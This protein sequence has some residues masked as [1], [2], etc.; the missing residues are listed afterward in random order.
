[1]AGQMPRVGGTAA[2]AEQQDHLAS[3]AQASLH[4]QRNCFLHK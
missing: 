2:I 3:D 1:M 4:S